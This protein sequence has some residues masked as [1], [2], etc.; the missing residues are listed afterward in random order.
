MEL[1][2]C[3][4]AGREE[5]AM[6]PARRAAGMCSRAQFGAAARELQQLD[7]CSRM[8]AAG[9]LR[10]SWFWW[11]QHGEPAGHGQFRQSYDSLH[12]R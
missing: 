9:G 2:A 12:R 3:E 10:C 8:A 5:P 1:G 6:E 7:G 4:G 11:L